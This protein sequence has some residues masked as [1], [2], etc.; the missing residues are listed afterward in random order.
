M[1]DEMRNPI[2]WETQA[3]TWE[4]SVA[5]VIIVYD[6]LP[7]VLLKRLNTSTMYSDDEINMFLWEVYSYQTTR[8]LIL[9]DS[10]LWAVYD[11]SANNTCAL[12]IWR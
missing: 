6:F 1:N 8:L 2:A 3:D 7:Q 11:F 9:E 10:T 4:E 12:H 5:Y